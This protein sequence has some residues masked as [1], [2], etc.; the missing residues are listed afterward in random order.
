MSDV[1]RAWAA[2]PYLLVAAAYT[3]SVAVA[4]L[5]GF[6]MLLRWPYYQ[7]LD[8]EELLHY[9]WSRSTYT[10]PYTGELRGPG[11]DEVVAHAP[12]YGLFAA[13]VL[14]QNR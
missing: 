12:A 7:L 3:A 8:P 1:G 14:P 11:G 13:A 4:E 2:G 9:P 6:D 10:H 5:L